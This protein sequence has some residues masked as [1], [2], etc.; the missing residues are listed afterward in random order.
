MNSDSSSCVGSLLQFSTKF[1]DQDVK[2][3]LFVVEKSPFYIIISLSMLSAMRGKMDFGAQILRL[4][5]NSEAL[6]LLLD[7]DSKST[8]RNW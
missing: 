5:V 4:Q 3:D 1:N 6:V 2:L 8:G 7:P